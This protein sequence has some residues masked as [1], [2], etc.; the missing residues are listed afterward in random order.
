M[1]G[2]KLLPG[3]RPAARIAEARLAKLYAA[4]APE[5]EE[6]RKLRAQGYLVIRAR[7]V[8]IAIRRGK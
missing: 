2:K 8:H 5:T 4:G 3:S 6:D 1:A 7:G